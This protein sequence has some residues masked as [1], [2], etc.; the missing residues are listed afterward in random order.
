MIGVRSAEDRAEGLVMMQREGLPRCRERS[1]W[2]A[3]RL[4]LGI[5]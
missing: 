3:V 1:G 4:I 2:P 5:A